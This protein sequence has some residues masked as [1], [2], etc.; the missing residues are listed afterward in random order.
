MI[1]ANESKKALL[2]FPGQMSN[3]AREETVL[4]QGKRAKMG[5]VRS[6]GIYCGRI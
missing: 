3:W 2:L 1:V 6:G 4:T 5:D